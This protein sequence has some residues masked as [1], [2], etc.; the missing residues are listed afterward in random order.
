MVENG[1]GIPVAVGF[2]SSRV[3]VVRS[4]VFYD[5]CTVNRPYRVVKFTGK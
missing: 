2:F 4:F 1:V 3:C 5:V